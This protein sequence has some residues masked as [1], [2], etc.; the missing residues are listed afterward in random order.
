MHKPVRAL[1]LPLVLLVA[2]QGELGLDANDSSAA[3]ERPSDAPTEYVHASPSLR[4]L[5]ISEYRNTLQDVFGV[6]YLVPEVLPDDATT[7]GL[8]SIAMAS[9]TVS[10]SAVDQ[11]EAAAFEVA[12]HIMD[13]P[14]KR[15]SFVPCNNDNPLNF[16]C[17]RALVGRA[18][19]KL[20]RRPVSDEEINRYAQPAL[21]AARELNNFDEGA[22]F[23]LA[24]LLQSPHFLYRSEYGEPDPERPGL[25]KLTGWEVASKLSYLLW[26]T[27]PSDATLA[28]AAEGKLSTP[29][30]IREEAERMLA[31]PQARLAME[32][33]WTEYLELGHLEKQVK[34]PYVF[35]DYDV[36]VARAMR[37][38]T[39]SVM[40]YLVFDAEAPMT[41]MFTTRT[42]FVNPQLA[43]IYRLPDELKP[44]RDFEQVELPRDMPRQGILG[45]ASILTAQ[46]HAVTTSPTFRGK[47]VKTALLCEPPP[48]PPPS[49]VAVLPEP[50]PEAGEQTL[51]QRL[52]GYFS[53][54][55]CGGCHALTDVIGFS[56]ENFNAIGAYRLNDNGLPVDAS[57]TYNNTPF[58]DMVGFTNLLAEDPKVMSCM[59]RRTFRHV[60][61]RV[62]GEGDAPLVVEIEAKYV[63]S[64][65]RFKALLLDIVGS[66]AFLWVKDEVAE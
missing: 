24:G 28:L 31:T 12:E 53:E 63:A 6:G 52:E 14:T 54:P 37:Q 46:S 38:E 41:E 35:P 40:S 19:T 20:W 39:L 16:E 17:M 59:A 49:V 44:Q 56:F 4:R 36:T 34:D 9:M 23:A 33:F 27:A 64:G 30:Q 18:A 65:Y 22:V 45:H 42:T 7:N 57:G 55:S 11:Y 26:G 60:M 10:P 48:P 32:G 51:R 29:E 13:S 50:D 25:R 8:T 5:T 58:E 43:K 47:F 61:G 2:C 21:V 1:L 15:G 62:E 3:S 66:E